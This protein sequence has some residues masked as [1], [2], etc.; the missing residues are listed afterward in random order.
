MIKQSKGI[1]LVTL[2][3]TIIILLILAGITI[4]QLTE[5]RLFNR[6]KQAK[7]KSEDAQKL[8]NETLGK[9][10]KEIEQVLGTRAENNSSWQR[11]MM[12]ENGYITGQ[13][14][15]DLP[16]RFEELHIKVDLGGALQY[17]YSILYEELEE[18]YRSYCNG[19][20][21][22]AVNDCIVNISK[23]K[24]QLSES[25]FNNSNIILNTTIKIWYK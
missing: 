5:N 16:E 19:F 7:E 17:T 13:E 2:V 10:E 22:G 14:E 6:I 15:I 3:I 9:Y 18:G 11:Y 24:L 20:N 12:N 23:T 4:S 1:T 8:E 21:N 25:W